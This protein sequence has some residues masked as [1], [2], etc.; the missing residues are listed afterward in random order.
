MEGDN[1]SMEPKSQKGSVFTSSFDWELDIK[2]MAE[3]IHS[4]VKAMVWIM[5][6]HNK[7]T[8]LQFVSLL[9]SL[10]IQKKFMTFVIRVLN[11][12]YA[13]EQEEH[14]ALEKIWNLKKEHM[15][16]ITDA[17]ADLNKKRTNP[18]SDELS[19]NMGKHKQKKKQRKIKKLVEEDENNIIDDGNHLVQCIEKLQELQEELEKINE[20]KSVELLKVEQ[21]YNRIRKPVYERRTNIIRDIPAFWSTAFLKHSILGGLVSTEE[22]HKIFKFLSSIT[23]EQS[24]D[25]KSGYTIIFDFEPNVYFE[26]RKLWKTY[27]FLEE[28]GHTKITTSSIQWV[29]DKGVDDDSFFRWFNEVT[30][31]DEIGEAIKD[32]WCDPLSCF[33]H[34]ENEE[35]GDDVAVKDSKDDVVEDTEDAEQD[36]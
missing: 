19:K 25:V 4:V 8:L 10:K 20:E 29:D 32:L 17:R 36:I 16:L 27:T 3:D 7:T 6:S 5:G 1:T 24:E 34:E 12:E 2:T 15:E 21:K 26:N 35:G 9:K 13:S 14:E 18:W 22:D 23:V 11:E 28:N 30:E 31:H 33:H